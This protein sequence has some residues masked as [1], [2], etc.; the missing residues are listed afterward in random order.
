V[1]PDFLGTTQRTLNRSYTIVAKAAPGW[2]FKEWLGAP[3]SGERLQ[4]QMSEDLEITA[5]FVPN[6]YLDKAGLYTALLGTDLAKHNARGAI[7]LQLN[8]AGGFTANLDLAGR[9]YPVRGNFDAL[10]NFFGQIGVGTKDDFI[11]LSF[12]FNPETESITLQVNQ[13]RGGDFSES[14]GLAKRTSWSTGKPCGSAGYYT[15]SLPHNSEMGPRGDGY[16]SI[17]V[18][19][20]GAARLAGALADG[21]PWSA[22]GSL[23]NESGL[24]IYTALYKGTGSISGR[25]GFTLQR[26]ARADGQFVWCLPKTKTTEAISVVI[27]ANALLYEAPVSGRSALD[28]I[29]ARLDLVEGGLESPIEKFGTLGADNRFVLEAPGA[30]NVQLSIDPATGLVSGTF[31]HPRYGVTKL[32]GIA[33]QHLNQIFGFFTG[34]GGSGSIEVREQVI[35]VR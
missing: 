35:F 2:T 18:S 10:G 4:F 8:R 21:T 30:E 34:K 17:T 19:P 20:L 32:R 16:A 27:D 14:Q 1:S 12:Q 28:F 33:K 23:D 7:A 11:Y 24:V 29:R 3:G 26:G 15:M 9:R 6:P 5:V 31:V 22:T 13:S 25:L